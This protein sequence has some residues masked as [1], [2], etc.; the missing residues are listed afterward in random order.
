M[1]TVRVSAGGCNRALEMCLT[2]V[3]AR[4]SGS[5]ASTES[6]SRWASRIDRTSSS[7][8]AARLRTCGSTSIRSTPPIR[9]PSCRGGQPGARAGGFCP[10]GTGAVGRS[11]R[12]QR[13]RSSRLRLHP[14]LWRWRP[15]RDSDPAPLTIQQR[16]I[17]W[18]P[19]PSRPSLLSAPPSSPP[20]PRITLGRRRGRALGQG[21]GTRHDSQRAVDVENLWLYALSNPKPEKPIHALILRG[22]EERSIVYGSRPRPSRTIRYGRGYAASCG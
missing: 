9:L 13:A 16:H 11:Q 12:R 4:R 5:S 14:R 8:R 21:R 17:T 10:H 2:G 22:A 18:G 3:S 19:S 6:P 7:P 15:G 1:P 20:A